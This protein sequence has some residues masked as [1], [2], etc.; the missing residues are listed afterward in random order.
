MIGENM[1]QIQFKCKIK[2][3]T[4][5]LFPPLGW[6][7]QIIPEHRKDV[8][9]IEEK[10]ERASDD[11]LQIKSSVS[12]EK[13]E[14][15]RTYN[16][17]CF[18]RN[19]NKIVKETVE[20]SLARKF[21]GMFCN[22]AKQFNI[23]PKTIKKADIR[24]TTFVNVEILKMGKVQDWLAE[25]MFEYEGT[26][27]AGWRFAEVLD[28]I[29]AKVTICSGLVDNEKLKKFIEVVPL[30]RIGSLSTTEPH[31]GHIKLIK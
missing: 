3:Y 2:N 7:K 19:E 1:G 15:I 17:A 12:A 9:G 14:K 8:Y 26:G 23:I 25:Q 10:I 31:L 28:E 29:E 22:T 13:L 24:R 11:S 5:D 16:C 6:M 18:I 21:F 30:F 20:Q 27:G 4:A